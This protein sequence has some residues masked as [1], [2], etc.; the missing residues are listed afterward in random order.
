MVWSYT[1]P[2]TPD[3]C[4]PAPLSQNSLHFSHHPFRDERA[5][6]LENKDGMVVSKRN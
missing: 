4:I 6:Q 1:V 5:I 3:M 2:G